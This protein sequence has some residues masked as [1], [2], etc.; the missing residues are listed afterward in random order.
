M[1]E[2]IILMPL[3]VFYS[4][5]IS[6]RVEINNLIDDKFRL[7]CDFCERKTY[8]EKNVTSIILDSDD[9]FIC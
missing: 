5:I 6:P 7:M 1:E 8:H 3:K 4:Y 9:F 2:V